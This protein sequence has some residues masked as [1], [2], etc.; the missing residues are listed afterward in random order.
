MKKT[1]MI[2]AILVTL[3]AVAATAPAEAR[4]LRFG[5]AAT[6]AA[7]VTA[8]AAAGVAASTYGYGPDYYAPDYRYFNP[9]YAVYAGPRFY[10]GWAPF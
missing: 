8:L 6:G 10:R 1:A 9:G 5:R 7:V 2:V 4:G 3:S